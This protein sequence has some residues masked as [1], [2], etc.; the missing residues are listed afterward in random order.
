M[1]DRNDLLVA[2]AVVAVVI[3]GLYYVMSP[4]QICMREIGQVRFCLIKTS[5]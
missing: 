2:V 5:W 4:Y 1:I 3:V